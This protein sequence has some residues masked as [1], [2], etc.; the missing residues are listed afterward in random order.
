[1]AMV[2]DHSVAL[3]TYDEPGHTFTVAACSCRWKGPLRVRR[4]QGA[5][6]AARHLDDPL[7]QDYGDDWHNVV[8]DDRDRLYAKFG[9]VFER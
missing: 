3:E 8:G 5:I 4:Q 1:M 9:P 6:D 2:P 7:R